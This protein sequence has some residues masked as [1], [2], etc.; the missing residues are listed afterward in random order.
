M[1]HYLLNIYHP[2]GDGSVPP[3]DVLDDIMREVGRIREEM[4]A[5]GV[6]VFSGGLASPGNATVLRMRGRDVHATDGPFL[7]SK[8]YIGGFTIVRVADLDAA[9]AWARKLIQVIGMPIEVRP[10]HEH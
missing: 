2:D 4:K 10:F 9:L 5:A 3:R 1:K 7:E 8:E 6:W